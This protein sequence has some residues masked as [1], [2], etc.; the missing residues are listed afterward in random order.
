[1]PR[2]VGR[3][4]AL[5]LILLSPQISA[6]RVAELGIITR[7]VADEDLELETGELVAKLA[8][9][10]TAAVGAARRLVLEAATRSYAKQ[11]DAEA[12]TMT[13]FATSHTGQEG[14]PAFNA[15]RAPDFAQ[16]GAGS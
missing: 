12:A 10:P 6:D 16:P 4:H 14:I 8:N 13:A 5:E 9:G 11:L 2:I 3:R 15:R 7:A 1:L